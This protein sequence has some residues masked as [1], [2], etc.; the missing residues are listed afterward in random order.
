MGSQRT[1][2]PGLLVL[3]ALLS[4][5]PRPAAALQIDVL[6]VS[7]SNSVYHVQVDAHIDAPIE[8]VRAILLD[9]SAMLQLD[10]SLKSATSTPEGDGL[11]VQ[12]EMEEC[13]FGVCRRLL[14][15]Q[16]VQASGNSISAQ[17]LAVQGS[18]FRSGMAHWQLSAKGAGTR[19]LFSA[20]S[21]PDLWV[22]PFIG[23]PA[24]IRHLR[25]K[26]EKSL[27]NLEQLARE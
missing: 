14:H 24:L 20:D 11:R 2:L 6:E 7:R 8:R 5:L 25:A 18:G 15:V 13:L 17:T 23:P 4:A 9:S 22:P 27:H 3:P 19:L 21:E 16:Q 12:S 10:P 1:L 26:A